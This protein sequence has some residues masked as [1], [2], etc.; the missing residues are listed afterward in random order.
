MTEL[1][2]LGDFVAQ[3]TGGIKLI[4]FYSPRCLRCKV[5]TS[6]LLEKLSKDFQ[7]KFEFYSLNGKIV[8]ELPTI[9]KIKIYPV[10]LIFQDGEVVERLDRTLVHEHSIRNV[11]EK[12]EST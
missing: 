8:T 9:F 3:M 2:T 7:D 10:I 5:V 11:L 4:Y 12:Y 1:V 6:P